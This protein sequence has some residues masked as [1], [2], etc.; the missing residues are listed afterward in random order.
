[1]YGDMVSYLVTV[2]SKSKDRL[3]DDLRERVVD[4]GLYELEDNGAMGVVVDNRSL[5]GLLDLFG[6]TV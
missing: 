3:D 4:L 6:L 2:V 1:M 5:E